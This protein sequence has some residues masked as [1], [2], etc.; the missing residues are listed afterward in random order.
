MMEGTVV[1]VDAEVVEDIE[2][3]A[4]GEHITTEEDTE[5]EVVVDGMD[6]L[7]DGIPLLHNVIGAGGAILF[8]L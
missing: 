7:T 5:V 4:A 8:V 3:E 2:V 6:S 1:E